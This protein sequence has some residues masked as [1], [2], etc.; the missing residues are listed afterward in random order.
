MARGSSW[1]E[2]TRASSCHTNVVVHARTKRDFKQQPPT[3]SESCF[4]FSLLE[5]SMNEQKKLQR[6]RFGMKYVGAKGGEVLSPS[7]EA[8]SHYS[9]SLVN[10]CEPAPAGRAPQRPNAKA[11]GGSFP[12]FSSF[13]LFFF[14][15]RRGEAAE[16]VATRG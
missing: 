11:D 12:T 4:A 16:I 6:E 14:F 13:L 15:R 1:R 8:F 2:L 9:A 10:F 5:G 3:F 7:R